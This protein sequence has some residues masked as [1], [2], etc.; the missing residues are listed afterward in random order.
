MRMRASSISIDIFFY[1]LPKCL[2]S[3][4]ENIEFDMLNSYLV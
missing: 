3:I 4:E 1:I 2:V